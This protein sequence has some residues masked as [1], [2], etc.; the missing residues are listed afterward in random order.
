[1]SIE[2]PPFHLR[3]VIYLRINMLDKVEL[4]VEYGWNYMKFHP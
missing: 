2:V 4:W 3:N 1:M